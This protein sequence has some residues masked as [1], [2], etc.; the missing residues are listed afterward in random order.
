MNT[1]STIETSPDAATLAEA[2]AARTL[3]TLGAALSQRPIAH[4]VV[5]GGSILEKVFAA[6]AHPT[7]I[8]WERV[9]V[10][11]GDE[12][13]V[14]ADSD[15]R[16]DVPASAELFDRVPAM[17]HRMPSSDAEFGDDVDAAARGYA[18]ELAG[19]AEG[20]VS[21]PAFDVALIGIGPD[22]HCCSLFPHHPVLTVTD[23]AVTAVRNSPKPPPTRLSFTF[24]TLEAVRNL[25]F[26]A[27][28]EGKADAVSRALS[29]AP[30]EDVPSGSVRGSD[31]TVW[32]ID[33]PAAS[34]VPADR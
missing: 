25:W 12:R 22:G 23:A 26:V 21:V 32:M 10:W 13:F 14:A 30:R 17:L 31:A 18:A 20:G 16:N 8:D 34:D 7:A 9:H 2:V 1:E 3:D 29:G 33:L 11:W 24:P 27:S 6:L 5:T 19:Y 28:G 15:E 4:L